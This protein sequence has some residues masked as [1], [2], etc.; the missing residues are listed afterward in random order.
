MRFSYYIFLINLKNSASWIMELLI[1]F[2]DFILIMNLKKTKSKTK[3]I[4]DY[5]LINFG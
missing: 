4:F 1:L 3:L 2:L 5:S